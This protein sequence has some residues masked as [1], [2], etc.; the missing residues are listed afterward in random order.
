VRDVTTIDLEIDDG[1]DAAHIAAIRR[2]C[3]MFV[4]LVAAFHE[5]I[6]NQAEHQT[7]ESLLC[8]VNFKGNRDIF[9]MLL[10]VPG[11][12]PDQANSNGCTALALA[13]RY[14]REEMAQALGGDARVDQNSTD[15]HGPMP[16]FMATRNGNLETPQVL[17][18]SR[19]V[20]AD[21]KDGVRKGIW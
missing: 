2:R 18:V 5:T 21:G 16:L 13:C 9:R 1:L 20:I 6:I 10:G 14:G 7:E 8:K 4:C 15:W 19:K 11:I 17:L 12:E 3:E